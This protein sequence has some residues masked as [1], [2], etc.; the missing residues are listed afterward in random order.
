MR[1]DVVSLFPEMFSGPLGHSILKRAQEAEVLTVNV[2]NLRDF[3]FDKHHIVDDYPFGGGA[4]MVMKPDPIFRAVDNIITASNIARRR[5][6]LMCPGG[7]RLDQQKVKELAR[8]RKS[9]V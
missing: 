1:I 7:H 4:G 5:I 3:A 2:T 6:I 8:D 9:V